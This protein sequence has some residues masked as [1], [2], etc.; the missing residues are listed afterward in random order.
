M[1]VQTALLAVSATQRARRSCPHFVLRTEPS[2]QLREL[3]PGRGHLL[4][5][6]CSCVNLHVCVDVQPGMRTAVTVAWEATAKVSLLALALSLLDRL[7]V[8]Q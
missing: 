6:S 7:R 2:V 3:G 5:E 1:G 8:L 4:T